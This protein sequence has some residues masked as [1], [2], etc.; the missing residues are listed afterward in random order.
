M[1]TN[2]LDPET[3]HGKCQQALGFTY[4]VLTAFQV[5]STTYEVLS[6]LLDWVSDSQLRYTTIDTL[7]KPVDLATNREFLQEKVIKVKLHTPH[8]Y[9]CTLFCYYQ[10][11]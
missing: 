2:G 7:L 3:Q 8:M 10:V 4:L 6:T 5:A 11:E 9:I 1:H